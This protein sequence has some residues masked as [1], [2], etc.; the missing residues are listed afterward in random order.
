MPQGN[1]QMHRFCY[2]DLKKTRK[3]ATRVFQIL[4]KHR[5]WNMVARV[6]FTLGFINN[7]CHFHTH[8]FWVEN[9]APGMHT[10]F[11]KKISRV[12][13]CLKGPTTSL[14]PNYLQ[15]AGAGGTGE[16]SSYIYI[17]ICLC[18]Y[19]HAQMGIFLD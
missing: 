2:K 9:L 6:F 19:A 11:P 3:N 14:H 8:L 7:Y 10:S 17:Y 4:K 1:S 15:T 12:D 5:F 18:A 13:L 16:A